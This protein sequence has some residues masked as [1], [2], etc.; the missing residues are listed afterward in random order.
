MKYLFYFAMAVLILYCCSCSLPRY[1]GNVSSLEG[2]VV[3]LD[4]NKFEVYENVPELG[5]YV[6]FTPTIHKRMANSRVIGHHCQWILCPYKTITPDKYV[7]SVIAYV[8]EFETIGYWLDI[9]HLKHPR[10]SYERLEKR[11]KK[12]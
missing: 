10:Y 12:R 9:L 2:N 4:S 7:D 6:T 8:G 3:T 1:V 5:E 11:A